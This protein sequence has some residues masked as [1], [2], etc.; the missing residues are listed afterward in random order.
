MSCRWEEKQV[1]IN[2]Q[3]R[4]YLEGGNLHPEV[5]ASAVS[6]RKG[7]D[8]CQLPPLQLF[9]EFTLDGSYLQRGLANK[10]AYHIRRADALMPRVKGCNLS[11]EPLKI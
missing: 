10:L 3:A 6:L 2:I 8:A 5:V 11:K 4:D 7:G 1:Q 9:F